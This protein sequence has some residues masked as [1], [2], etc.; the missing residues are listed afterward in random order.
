MQSKQKPAAMLQ[1]IFMSNAF[2]SPALWLTLNF[3]LF[4]VMN[5]LQEMWISPSQYIDLGAV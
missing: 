3:A 4:K 2:C 1:G 5:R